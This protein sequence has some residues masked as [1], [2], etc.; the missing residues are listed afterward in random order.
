MGHA[1]NI[2]H[3]EDLQTL[4]NEKISELEN[5]RSKK[6]EGLLLR[7]HPNWYDNGEKCFQYFCKH[8]KK[9][10]INLNR[11]WQS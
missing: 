10:H 7:S 4:L 3:S 11:Q 6:T 5:Q 2:Y 1:M 9:N 8:E